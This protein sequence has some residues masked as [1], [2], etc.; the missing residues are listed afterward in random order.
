MSEIHGSVRGDQAALSVGGAARKPSNHL[1]LELVAMR[2]K[3]VVGV[4]HLHEGGT[5]WIGNGPDSIARVPLREHGGHPLIV[6]DVRAGT[7]AVH[8]PPRARARYHGGDGIPRLLVGPQRVELRHGERA[9]LVM[10]GVSIRAQVVPFEVPCP[11]FRV[12]SGAAAWMAVLG[13]LYAAAVVITAMLS[14]PSATPAQ[15]G[16]MVRAHE[17]FLHGPAHAAEPPPAR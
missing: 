15:P 6:G 5:A 16:G 2:G 12:T 3:D 14:R 13:V 4:R 11:R 8:V 10:G 7:F 17:R 1:S 9:V